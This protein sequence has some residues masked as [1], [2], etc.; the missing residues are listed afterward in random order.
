MSGL[1]YPELVKTN[2]LSEDVKNR[3][4]FYLSQVGHQSGIGAYTDP[5]GYEFV[6]KS[7]AEFI[8]KRDKIVDVRADTQIV[9]SNGMHETVDILLQTFIKHYRTGVMI[10]TPGIHYYSTLISQCGGSECQYKISEGN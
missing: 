7:I 9:L 8:L 5:R 2:L 10:P 6:R 3:V 4:K 1:L